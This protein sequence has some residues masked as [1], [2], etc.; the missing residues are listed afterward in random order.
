MTKMFL[1]HDFFHNFRKVL[2]TKTTNKYEVEG[3]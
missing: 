1:K 2:A 3:S